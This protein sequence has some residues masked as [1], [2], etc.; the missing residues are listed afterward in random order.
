MK[1][2]QKSL[3]YLLEQRTTTQKQ[4]NWLAKLLGHEFDIVYK[5]GALNKVTV[6]LSRINEDKE[7]DEI[8]KPFW[9]DIT[10]IDAEAHR[11]LELAKGRTALLHDSNSM[12]TRLH[13]EK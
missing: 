11:D 2:D 10:K 9:Q 12:S 1:Q 3:L 13:L 6:A 7:L 8:S 5:V 4:Q